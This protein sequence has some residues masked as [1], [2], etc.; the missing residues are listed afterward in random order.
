MPISLD[1]FPVS[2]MQML[3]EQRAITIGFLIFPGFP[4]SC[5]TSMIEPLRAAN[6]IA[7]CV[8]FKWKI[9]SETGARVASGAPVVFG[10]DVTL[11]AAG[12]VVHF[13]RA[14]PAHEKGSGCHTGDVLRSGET[15]RLGAFDAEFFH[16][17]I[18]GSGV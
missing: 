17:R 10:A 13:R 15:V 12:G 7:D 4:M 9:L 6:E 8:A 11:A 2:K 5:L 14:E 3:A 1:K 18:E 16:A